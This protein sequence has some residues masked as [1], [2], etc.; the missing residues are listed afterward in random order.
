[1]ITIYRDKR[2]NKESLVNI[3][4]LSWQIFDWQGLFCY[5]P[6]LY[7]LFRWDLQQ[8]MSLVRGQEGPNGSG[9]FAG[10]Q[11]PSTCFN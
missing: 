8:Q 5:C 7:L 4:G 2:V 9:R 1:M 6:V 3:Y 11:E 10:C